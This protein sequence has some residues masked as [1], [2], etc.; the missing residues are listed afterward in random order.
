LADGNRRFVGANLLGDLGKD[1]SIVKLDP[2]VGCSIF[3]G[4]IFRPPKIWTERT[5]P[6]S[7]TGTKSTAA[8]TSLG[9]NSRRF[10]F[11]KCGPVSGTCAKLDLRQPIGSDGA[12]L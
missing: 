10:L 2:P 12:I 4:D 11:A 5:F 1:F 8:A 3:Q 6:G 7:F 9:S